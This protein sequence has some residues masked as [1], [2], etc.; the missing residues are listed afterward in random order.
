L[1]EG[2][3]VVILRKIAN[4]CYCNDND[5]NLNYNLQLNLINNPLRYPS[6]VLNKDG[7][8]ASGGFRG[9]KGREGVTV[10]ISRKIANFCY[11]NDNE[12]NPNYTVYVLN[13]SP[14]AH[15]HGEK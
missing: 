5:T 1:R 13:S 11:C 12:T 15:L 7:F 4:F 10:V 8:D 9:P 14:N 6:S 2:V 3:T